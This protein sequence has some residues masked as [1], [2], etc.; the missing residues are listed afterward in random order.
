[1]QGGGPGISRGPGPFAANDAC[2]VRGCVVAGT[3]EA[4]ARPAMATSRANMRMT[5]FIFG[6]LKE[7]DFK[8]ESSLSRQESYHGFKYKSIFFITIIR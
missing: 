5:E 4:E 7:L 6:N 1:V 3:N 2:L 8:K